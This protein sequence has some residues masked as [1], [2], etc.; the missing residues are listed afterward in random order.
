MQKEEVEAVA[1]FFWSRAGSAAWTWWSKTQWFLLVDVPFFWGHRERSETFIKHH[2]LPVWPIQNRLKKK[3][4]YQPLPP[5]EKEG[6]FWYRPMQ[7]RHGPKPYIVQRIEHWSAT[8]KLSMKHRPPA[9]TGKRDWKSG[10]P[11]AE[12]NQIP[13]IKRRKH[14]KWEATSKMTPPVFLPLTIPTKPTDIGIKTS[15][16]MSW[17]TSASTS[18]AKFDSSLAIF[19]R[20]RTAE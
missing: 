16:I 6:V 10:I 13:K 20:N 12:G 17:R 7:G 19:W 8:K 14:T 18:T 15:T 11:G 4:R 3:K 2:F 5:P 9:D 1:K